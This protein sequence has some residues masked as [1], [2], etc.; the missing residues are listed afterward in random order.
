MFR[1]SRITDLV[2]ILVLVALALLVAQRGAGL[3]REKGVAVGQTTLISPL[4]T[5]PWPVPTSTAEPSPSPTIEPVASATPPINTPAPPLD[6]GT[7]LFEAAGELYWQPVDKGGNTLAPA[8]RVPIELGADERIVGLYPSPD[9]KQ[10]IFFKADPDVESDMVYLLVLLDRQARPLLGGTGLGLGTKFLGWHPNGRQVAYCGETVCLLHDV[11]TDESTLLTDISTLVNLPYAP[12]IDG[13][14]G[15]DG[16]A[17][18][19]DGQRL[20]VSYTDGLGQFGI[21]WT[22]YSDGSEPQ[23]LFKENFR[24]SAMAWSPDGKHIA[25]VGN[26]VEVMNPDGQNRRTVGSGFIGG[27]PPAWSPDGRYLAFTAEAPP[28]YKVRIVD[29]MSGTER[30][31]VSDTSRSDVS[32]VW[33]PDGAWILFLSD[34][35]DERGASEV[36]IAKP[37]GAELRQLTADGKPKRSAP[38]WLPTRR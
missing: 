33:S 13:A 29:V 36:W 23:L 1:K 15:V 21:V 38:V 27:R 8:V 3:L 19:P 16:L 20:I 9:W 37:D 22:L 6:A 2:I 35:S 14:A 18:A 4:P 30:D 32:P 5:A 34:W 28:A 7:I 10:V 25:F 31:L 12:L 24:I 26:G 17:F 11:Y